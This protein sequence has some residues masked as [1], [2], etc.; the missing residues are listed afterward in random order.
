MNLWTV[1]K[2]KVEMSEKILLYLIDV[3]SLSNSGS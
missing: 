3:P 2:E 1:R